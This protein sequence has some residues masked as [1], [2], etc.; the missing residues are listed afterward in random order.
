MVVSLGPGK[1]YG[2]SLP[3]PRIYTD[4]KFN[5]HRVDP[6]LPVTDPFMSWAQE[7]HWS[8]G[9]LSFKRLR[10]QGKIE[11]NVHKLRS[12]REKVQSLSPAPAHSVLAPSERASSPSPPPAPVVTKRRRYMDLIVDEEEE[13]EPEEV[14][15]P[16]T[17]VR[18]S[19]LVKKLGDDFD[20]VA[21]EKDEPETMPLKTLT[22][23]RRLVKSA[24]KK[25][26]V[27]T[28]QKSKPNGKQSASEAEK[29]PR[30]RTSPRL[31]K[32]VSS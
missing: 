25:T 24:E 3:R 27:E 11:G 13:E 20:R 22:R 28:A 19:R 29:S 23:S 12:Q 2:T 26:V 7:A 32:R 4:V 21:Q 15:P 18:K 30:V 14:E 6:P 10:L 8:M 5:D 31:A 1:F 9:G 16:R 17:R